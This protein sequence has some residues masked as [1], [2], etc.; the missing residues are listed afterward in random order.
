[1]N[2]KKRER[3]QSRSKTNDA[4]HIKSNGNSKICAPITMFTR[5]H[6]FAQ[7]RLKGFHWLRCR[8]RFLS[9]KKLETPLGGLLFCKS[10]SK[11]ASQRRIEHTSPSNLN[12]NFMQP[13]CVCLRVCVCAKKQHLKFMFLFYSPHL[14]SLCWDLKRGTNWEYF[15]IRR[16][17][18]QTIA[19]LKS[20]RRMSQQSPVCEGVMRCNEDE[21]RVW[22]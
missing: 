5:T 10:C 12:G 22:R 16:E 17:I 14:S 13:V 6:I 9:K 1:M 18:S 15:G 20:H 3:P 4:K 11:R 21:H 19:A 7:L 8:F 2:L